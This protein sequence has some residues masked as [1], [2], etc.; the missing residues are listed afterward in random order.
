MGSKVTRGTGTFPLPTGSIEGSGRVKQEEIA[1]PTAAEPRPSDP[2]TRPVPRR[3][4]T[5]AAFGRLMKPVAA[6][7]VASTIGM[8]C[9]A[10]GQTL[11]PGDLVTPPPVV[12][13]VDSTSVP[14]SFGPGPEVQREYERALQSLYERRDRGQISNSAFVKARALL[15]GSLL[16]NSGAVLAR[17]HRGR[18]DIDALI[19][20]GEL[21]PEAANMTRGQLRMHQLAETLEFQMRVTARDMATGN[22]TPLEGAPGYKELSQNQM[23]RLLTDALQDLPLNELPGG[24]QLAQLVRQ[25]PLTDEINPETMSVRELGSTLGREYRDWFKARAEPL[26]E[27]RELEVGLVAFG[28]VTALRAS[29]PDAASLMDDLNIRST[30]YSHHSDD[31]RT[32]LRARIAYRDQ[33]VFPDL[34]LEART[35]YVHGDTTFRASVVGTFSAEADDILSGTATVGARHDFTN[36]SYIDASGTYMTQNDR[37]RANITYGRF[38]PGD[39]WNIGTGVAAVFGDGVAV[40]DASGRLTWQTDITKDIRLGNARG[41][42]G[43]YL[44]VGA[45]SDFENDEVMAGAVFRLKF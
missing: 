31:Q 29:S 14:L 11:E 25:L 34:D 9:A 33:H 35:R 5:G 8:G 13:T 32:N 16:H 37:W 40:G 30:I 39:G 42:F 45:D 28:A 24:A 19:T 12:Q 23:R 38:D 15:E 27:G 20:I 43:F 3:V 21:G 1:P 41:D 4:E 7:L 44:G 6:A 17:D 22:F 36:F 2:A 26:I 10:H 18:V